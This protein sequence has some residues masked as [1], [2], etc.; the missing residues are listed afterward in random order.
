MPWGQ[1]M[2]AISWARWDSQDPVSK[3]PWPIGEAWLNRNARVRASALHFGIMLHLGFWLD[4]FPPL[5][6]RILKTA[7]VQPSV[8]I[9]YHR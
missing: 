8:S 3:K 7:Y 4:S 2:L 6:S 1:A 9:R 5:L